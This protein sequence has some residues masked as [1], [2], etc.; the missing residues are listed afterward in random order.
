MKHLLKG[1]LSLALLFSASL[2]VA[3]GSTSCGVGGCG[4]GLQNRC[5]TKCDFDCEEECEDK[6][7]D[8]QRFC[9][10]FFKIRSQGSD[11]A[12]RLVGS[13]LYRHRFD[14]DKLYGTFDVTIAYYKNFRREKLTQYFLPSCPR[15][16]TSG[17]NSFIEP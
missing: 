9:K 7:C 16:Q 11:T 17:I 13:H 8:D 10:P 1:F 15:I 2:A 12:R 5:T 14:M 6:C 4:G 3:A